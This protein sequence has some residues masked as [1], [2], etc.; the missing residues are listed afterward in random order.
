MP[1]DPTPTPTT[2]TLGEG[3]T[4][5]IRSRW[6][7]PRLGVRDLRFK[8]EH[9]NPSGSYKDRFAARFVGNHLAAGYP[10]VLATSSGNTGAALATYAAAAGLPCIVCV[11]VEAPEAKLAQI[12][13]H[14]AVVVRVR[15]MLDT[16][17]AVRALIDRLAEV[18]A[19]MGMPLGTSAYEI[20]PE[21]MAGIEPLGAEIVAEGAPDRIFAPVGGGG[22]VVATWRGAR[23]ASA[24][25]MPPR[26][27]AVQ[28]AG[29]DTV[30]TAFR[31]GHGHAR[32]LDPGEAGT[33]V[34]GL[35]VPIDLDATRALHAVRDSGGNG[36][37]VA[38]EAAWEA[39]ATLSRHEGLFVEPAGA[40]SVAGLMAAVAAGE[41][42]PDDRVTCI[43]T[44]S[45]FK[46]GA[47][48][49]RMASRV[50]E[51]PGSFAPQD[52]GRAFFED[53]IGRP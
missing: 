18:C 25:T 22:L 46:D 14:G 7:G 17:D 29:N 49:A 39:Q 40:T 53:L 19:T 1:T 15:G 27:H 43:L 23:D 36:H 50:P 28:P 44:G 3:H 52:L 34:S 10:F 48:V 38:D 20:A 24:T 9:L 35:A 4:P 26:I 37:L 11:P 42:G 6:L 2:L 41:V 33:N 5:L 47:A 51:A 30:V 45:G 12:R 16:P 31:A 21:A 13:A 8:L 32:T